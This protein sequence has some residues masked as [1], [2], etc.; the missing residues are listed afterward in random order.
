M[1]AVLSPVLESGRYKLKRDEFRLLGV[2]FDLL[3]CSSSLLQ[4]QSGVNASS[5][6]SES[7][8]IY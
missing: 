8:I 1:L 2:G 7:V 3:L 6:I 5:V 4:P